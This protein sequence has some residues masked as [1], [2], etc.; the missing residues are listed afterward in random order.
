MTRIIISSVNET[1]RK[2]DFFFFFFVHAWKERPQTSL[3]TPASKPF[4]FRLLHKLIIFSP[5]LLQVAFVVFIY[6]QT[7]WAHGN[8]A[9]G[10]HSIK[11]LCCL[12]AKH[13]SLCL[14]T[15]MVKCVN[16]ES[17]DPTLNLL[18]LLAR[19]LC[20]LSLLAPLLLSLLKLRQRKRKTQE[21][22]RRRRDAIQIQIVQAV[23]FPLSGARG[24][25]LGEV[26]SILWQGLPTSQ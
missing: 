19:L 6:S 23:F 25:W 22:E 15:E 12:V 5:P 9:R 10:S 20:E 7:D 14:A 8:L 3:M 24:Q 2:Q 11:I 13:L 18:A 4:R 21:K 16:I 17:E 1:C 26:P